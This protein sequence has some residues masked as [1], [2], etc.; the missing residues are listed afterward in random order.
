VHN[1]Y[2][3]LRST[4]FVYSKLRKNTQRYLQSADAADLTPADGSVH[5]NGPV[6]SLPLTP[7]GRSS[8]SLCFSLPH[9]LDPTSFI[10]TKIHYVFISLFQFY[11]ALLSAGD[12]PPPLTHDVFL[13]YQIPFLPRLPFPHPEALYQVQFIH[14]LLPSLPPSYRP[15]SLRLNLYYPSLLD[16]SSRRPGARIIAPSPCRADM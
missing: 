12:L 2:Y 6:R 10:P 13:T 15:P 3:L 9:T 5:Q 16:F 14:Q 7:R 8:E 1:R 11:P 4:H